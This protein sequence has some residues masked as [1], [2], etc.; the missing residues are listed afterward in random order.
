M[1]R[2]ECFCDDKRVA[3]ILHALSGMAYEVKAVPVANAKKVGGKLR[4][5]S[6]SSVETLMIGI[7]KRKLKDVGAQDMKAIMIEAGF[8]DASYSHPLKE[9]QDLG[10]LKRLPATNAKMTRYRVTGK[11]MPQQG[12]SK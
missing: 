9:A 12:A 6:A 10:L 3:Q 7:A 5:I 1:F 8:K 4:Q 11:K 2:I